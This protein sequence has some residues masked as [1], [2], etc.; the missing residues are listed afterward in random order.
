MYSVR[1]SDLGNMTEK[2]RE[3]ELSQVMERAQAPRNGQAAV[4]AAKIK[5]FEVRYEM[6]SDQMIEELMAGR[7]QETAEISRWLF[8]YRAAAN[9]R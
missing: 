6:T 1:L 9:A 7:R 5:A 4:L 8:W 2:G 3:Q